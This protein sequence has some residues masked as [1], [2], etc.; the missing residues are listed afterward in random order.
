M[1]DWDVGVINKSAQDRSNWFSNDMEHVMMHKRNSLVS[2]IIPVYNVAPYLREALD[3]VIHQTYRHLEIIVVDDGSTDGSGAIC[4][5]YSLDSRVQVIHQDNQGPSHARNVGLDLATGEFIA[6]LDSDD[7][8]H[9]DFIWV[10][11]NA[12]ENVDVVECQFTKHHLSLNS[13]GQ[14]VLTAKEG[15][16]NRAQ[17]LRNLIDRKLSTAVWNK[18]YRRTLWNEI[19]FR[20]GHFYEDIDVL[21]QIC[22]QINQLYYLEQSLVCYRVRPG[23]TTHTVS[24]KHAKDLKLSYDNIIVYV[25]SHIPDVFDETHLYKIRQSQMNGAIKYYSQGCM[26]IEE[27][28]TVCGNMDLKRVSF[29]TRIAYQMICYCPWLLKAVYPI[30]YQLKMSANRVFRR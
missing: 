6:F 28:K 8:Y 22:D 19:K 21:F 24:H 11:L 18:L 7:A 25:E 1:V 20:E 5:E 10:M 4:D 30:Y 17:T 12:I 16:Y 9:P 23:S 13:H 27:V 26:N 3:S 29:R 14:A 15:Y 2:I